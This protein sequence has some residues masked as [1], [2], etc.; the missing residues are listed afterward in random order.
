MLKRAI[1]P[2]STF[3]AIAPL[4]SRFSCFAGWY[5][6]NVDPVEFSPIRTSPSN[7]RANPTTLGHA[8]S[9]ASDLSI[10]AAARIRR[11]EGGGLPAR[12]RQRVRDRRR[13]GYSGSAGTG[14]RQGCGG[15]LG[16]GGRWGTDGRR[17]RYYGSWAPGHLRF[18]R[19]AC[20]LVKK[21][22][23]VGTRW[24]YTGAN[25]R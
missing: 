6:K 2:L 7:R 11:L 8:W 17:R 21:P 10:A 5:P 3:S 1:A 15:C 22:N 24:H 9:L 23:N 13:Q 12:R 16:A 14:G 4:M 25:P 19:P 20:Y 18:M